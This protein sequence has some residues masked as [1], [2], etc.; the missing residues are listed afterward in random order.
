[1]ST[2]VSF[3]KHDDILSKLKLKELLNAT[4]F[5]AETRQLSFP[6]AFMQMRHE[7][8]HDVILD[9]LK[10]HLVAA[11]TVVPGAFELSFQMMLDPSLRQEGFSVL[12]NGAQYPN[13]TDVKW[14]I[15]EFIPVYKQ[16]L[17][18]LML[19]ALTRAGFPGKLMIEVSKFPAIV[20]RSC[21]QFTVC[22]S[23]Q[24]NIELVNVVTIVVD[25]Y[26]SSP[27]ELENILSECS[28]QHVPIVVFARGFDDEVVNTVAV[29]QKRGVLQCVLVK[30]PFSEVNLNVLGDI[31]VVCNSRV[32]SP[33]MGQHISTV[34]LSDLNFV[35]SIVIDDSNVII[36]APY[37]K[38]IDDRVLHIRSK[39][40][41][42]DVLLQANEARIRSLS[43]GVISVKVTKEDVQLVDRCLRGY[44][45]LVDRG[46]VVLC[47]RKVLTSAV[48]ASVLHSRELDT[49]LRS[50]S[51]VIY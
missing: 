47:G 50:M 48:A 32:V 33:M 29:N 26:I 15:D 36:T 17:R 22:R 13:K 46:T 45:S 2:Q 6:Q 42:N 51:A 30:V 43:P 27:I 38:T 4:V 34:K 23:L 31:A 20:E 35:E 28:K 8:Y 39:T 14:V 1:M 9:V 40:E 37:T 41:I 7:S 12:Q 21:F 5:R 44:R 16:K 10:T 3:V 18:A 24:K 11:E 49:V 25:G 19:Q